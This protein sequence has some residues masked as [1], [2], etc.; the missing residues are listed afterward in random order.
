[1]REVSPI[2]FKSIHTLSFNRHGDRYTPLPASA[3]WDLLRCSPGLREDIF[4]SLGNAQQPK[5]GYLKLWPVKLLAQLQVAQ[6]GTDWT[7]D[8][9]EDPA[10]VL[11]PVAIP[12]SGLPTPAFPV[13]LFTPHSAFL[14]PCSTSPNPLPP[15]PIGQAWLLL[16]L[17][18]QA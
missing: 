5:R 12:L 3:S 15:T 1:M 8:G 2:N 11:D 7:R 10:Q 9:G 16:A 18:C 14:L 6:I 17:Y 13:S 4:L